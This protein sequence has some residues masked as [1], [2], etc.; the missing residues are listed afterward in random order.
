LDLELEGVLINAMH[1][2]RVGGLPWTRANPLAALA[3]RLALSCAHVRC[4]DIAIRSHRHQTADTYDNYP[5]RVIALPAWQLGTEFGNRLGIVELADIGGV[6][7]RAE[8]GGYD[9]IKKIYKPERQ[10]VWKP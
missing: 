7:I 4:P 6:I 8:A 2:G 1:H 9:V 5:V 3:I 10:R